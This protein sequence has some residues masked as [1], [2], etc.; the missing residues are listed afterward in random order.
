VLEFP[1]NPIN[2]LEARFATLE[3]VKQLGLMF[4]TNPINALEA[5]PGKLE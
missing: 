4:P 1:T 5:R 2:A 3:P